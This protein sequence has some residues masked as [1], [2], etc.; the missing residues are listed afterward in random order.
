MLQDRATSKGHY[1]RCLFARHVPFDDL[2]A[3]SSCAKNARPLDVLV[4][5]GDFFF[6]RR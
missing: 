4:Q 5:V 2:T 3:S 6:V 1:K